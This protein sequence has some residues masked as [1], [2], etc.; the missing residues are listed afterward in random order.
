[1]RYRLPKVSELGNVTVSRVFFMF[2]TGVLIMSILAAPTAFAYP[3]QTKRIDYTPQLSSAAYWDT[4]HIAIVRIAASE[5][6]AMGKRQLTLETFRTLSDGQVPETRTVPFSHFF[7]LD[8][9]GEIPAEIAE[10]D[11]MA[12]FFKKTGPGQIAAAKL[13]AEF[14]SSPLVQT[15]VRIAE[16]REK[17]S[18]DAFREGVFSDDA[19]VALYCLQTMLHR[20]PADA[21]AYGQRLLKL[22]NDEMRS[23]EVRLLASRVRSR[24]RGLSDKSDEEYEWLRSTLASSRVDD[25]TQLRPFATRLLE[26]PS[27][28]AETVDFLVDLALNRQARKTARIAAYSAFEEPELFHF[29]QPDRLSDRIVDACVTLL[30]DP[31]PMFRMAGSQLLHNIS[32]EVQHRSM[33]PEAA[34]NIKD[35]ARTAL[36]NALARESDEVSRARIHEHYDS[37][38]GN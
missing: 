14:E 5:T 17:A 2:L 19:I 31:D 1:M 4:H 20:S 33:N 3:V 22:R 10:G 25:W 6:N 7:W 34:R 26:F 27:R 23:A 15:L 29:Q 36:S 30:Q 9:A 32:H 18:L 16:L 35:Q 13:P 12:V 11:V 8:S 37:L 28:R 38:A 24:V 21:D